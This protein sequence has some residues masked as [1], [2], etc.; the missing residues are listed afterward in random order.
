MRRHGQTQPDLFMSSAILVEICWSNESEAALCSV[1]NMEPLD[2]PEAKFLAT[3]QA[4]DPWKVEPRVVD[5]WAAWLPGKKS[6]DKDKKRKD[7]KDK[8]KDKEKTKDP[9]PKRLHVKAFSL[10]VSSRLSGPR[11]GALKELAEVFQQNF[12]KAALPRFVLPMR[13]GDPFVAPQDG[14]AV[15]GA[16]LHLAPQF[17]ETET[18][19]PQQKELLDVYENGIQCEWLECGSFLEWV[20]Y[21]ESATTKMARR[22]EADLQ[23]FLLFQTSGVPMHSVYH[24]VTQGI[25]MFSSLL[26]NS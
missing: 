9:L 25:T 14:R 11:P 16:I 21:M 5:D 4:F 19:S 17:Q 2:A 1:A 10:T 15:V 13:D 23:I 22:T 20:T 8:D 24:T 3:V 12:S 7:K 26:Y 6:G 18:L